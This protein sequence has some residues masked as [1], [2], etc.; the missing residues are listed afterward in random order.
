MRG[1][2]IAG[3]NVM[4]GADGRKPSERM[5][6]RELLQGLA[7]LATSGWLPTALA[8]SASSTPLSPTQFSAASIACTGYAFDDPRVATAMLR[9]LNDSVGRANLIRLAK[10]AINTPPGQLDAALKTA[11]MERTAEIVVAAFY[12][13][14]VD[15]PKGAIVIS[16]DQALVWQACVWTK[17]NAFCGGPTNYWADAPTGVTS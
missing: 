6:R 8:Q 14:T 3:E 12:T 5:S 1:A 13:G 11:G 15:G 10:L 2:K 7:A 16:Y 17:P 4:N 9:A